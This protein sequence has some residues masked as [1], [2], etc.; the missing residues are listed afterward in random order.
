M[1]LFAIGSKAFGFSS[2][3]AVKVGSDDPGPQ[4]ITACSPV[5]AELVEWGIA[6]EVC[7]C[8]VLVG[9]CGLSNELRFDSRASEVH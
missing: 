4:R 2:G 9:L 8:C 3:F 1:G 6:K 7:C 5:E